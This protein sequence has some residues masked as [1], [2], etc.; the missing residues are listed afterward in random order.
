MRIGEVATITKVT[1]ESIRHYEK[2]KLLTPPIRSVSGQRL[3]NNEHI[4][5]LKI[6][7]QLRSF[8]FALRDIKLLFTYQDNPAGHS[9]REVKQLVEYHLV[10][11]SDMLKTLSDTHRYLEALSDECDGGSE[12]AGDCPILKSL[13]R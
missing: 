3:Y 6:I 13:V 8:D 4:S 10:K 2:I 5:Q 9:K 1:V 7:R 12:H 11:L